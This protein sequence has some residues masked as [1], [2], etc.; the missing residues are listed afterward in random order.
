MSFSEMMTVLIGCVLVN[1]YVLQHFVGF[2]HIGEDSKKNALYNAK[3]AL[4][5]T[6]VLVVAT[7]IT[8]PIEKWVISPNAE[9]ARTLVYVLVTAFS[10]FAVDKLLVKR[11]EKWLKYDSANVVF[12]S[13][14]LGTLLLAQSYQYSWIASYFAVVGTGIGYFVVASVVSGLRKR[15]DMKAVPES[16][17]GLPIYMATLAIMS[18]AVFAFA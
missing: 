15:I 8:Y 10:S 13:I 2:E 1:N 12:N 14:V 17:R 11:T 18:L 4:L 5:L 16:F 3:V 6:L 7:T 9:W